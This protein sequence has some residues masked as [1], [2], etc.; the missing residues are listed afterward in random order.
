[1]CDLVFH[2]MNPG[3]DAWVDRARLVE[4][5]QALRLSG[6]SDWARVAPTGS[7]SLTFSESFARGG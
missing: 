1:M 6:K 5:C 7:R 3:T 2:D 4:C